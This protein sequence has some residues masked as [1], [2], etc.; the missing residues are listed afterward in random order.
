MKQF[1]ALVLVLAGLS[2]PVFA[3]KK[4]LPKAKPSPAVAASLVRGKA[5]YAQHCLSCHQ[6]DG[7]GVEGLHP[8]LIITNEVL[9]D[10]PKM[11]LAVLM[12]MQHRDIKG[13]P[14]SGAMPPMDFLTD[15][16]IADVLTYV[17]Q[18]FGNKATAVNAA[19]VTS[20]RKVVYLKGTRYNHPAGPG[21]GW[22]AP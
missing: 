6:A 7:T 16:Q 17:R 13:K 19:E 10:R 21:D 12:G 18:N 11:V 15:Q 9:G 8:P 2:S 22:Q 5:L 1:L 4:P 20:L 3:Q 14:Y